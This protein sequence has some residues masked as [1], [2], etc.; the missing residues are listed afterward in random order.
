[1]T[2]LDGRTTNPVDRREHNS[3]LQQLTLAEG[4]DSTPDEGG[5]VWRLS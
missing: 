2:E 4:K 5:E 1:M 3:V